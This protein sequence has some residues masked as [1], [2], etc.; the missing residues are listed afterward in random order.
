MTQKIITLSPQLA[1]Q[2]AAGEVVERPASVVKELV[3]NSL[4]AGATRIDIRLENGG[5]YLIEVQD[6]GSWIAPDQL[7][8]AIKK[9]STSKIGD[10]QDLYEVMTFWFRWE[11][12][13]SISS[14]S[15]F[16]ITSKVGDAKSGSRIIVDPDGSYS[17]EDVSANRGTIVRVWYLFCNTPARLSYLKQARTEYRKIVE[18]V[19]SIALMYPEVWFFVLH[20]G[21]ESLTLP[22][23]NLEQR[24]YKIYGKEFHSNI[25]P[26]FHSFDGIEVSW[27]ISDPKV[28]FRTK[29]KQTIGVNKR[30]IWSPI[31]YKAISDAYN[32][33]IPHGTFPW[34]VLDIK[35][36]PTIIDANVHPRKL[37]IRFANEASIFRSVYHGVKDALEKVSLS[38]A[39]G[40]L[41]GEFPV[42]NTQE[43]N[44]NTERPASQQYYTWSG[45]NFKNYSPYKNTTPNPAQVSVDFSW[46]MPTSDNEL[47]NT[48][49]DNKEL[50]WDLSLTPLGKILWQLHNAYILVQTDMWLKIL[51][52][53]ALAERVLYEK[54]SKSS[55]V[56]KSQSILWWIGMHISPRELESLENYRDNIEKLWFEVDIMQWWNIVLQ[57][58]PDFISR[59]NIEESFKKILWD[60]SD[61]WSLSLD[62]V[63]HKIWAYAAC[64]WS[65]KFG[66]PL[67][68]FEM[69]A[70]LRDASLDYSA[71]CPHGRPVVYDISLEDLLWKYER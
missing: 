36:D 65:V 11:A 5:I 68:L 52:Q 14:V 47:S 31:I 7:K 63:Q 48:Q 34:Y 42:Q 39:P 24:I 27:Y 17:Q 22:P 51:D 71:T 58:I 28:N 15:E 37:E 3:E 45:T 32:R 33:F 61:M 25:I 56:P 70:L 41:S 53:H 30:I 64:R 44:P 6:N 2:I 21:K 46:A 67:S 50:H 69:N 20:D 18:Y 23:E 26:T 16:S 35:I 19:Q 9:Y 66:D 40:A 62:E 4:D 60:I 10:L 59:Q 55:H 43:R 8:L 57:S 13:A 12:L 54:L 38:S 29:Q 49:D 1:N